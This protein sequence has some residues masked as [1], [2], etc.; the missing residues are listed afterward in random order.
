MTGP[1]RAWRRLAHGARPRTVRTRVT[2]IAGLAL[3]AAVIIGLLV[4]YLLQV[5][6][7]KRT[8]AGQL[9]TYAVQI[10]QSATGGA[11][12]QPLPPS[13]L[14]AQAQSQVLAPD[15]T[16]IASTRNL[17]GRPAVFTLAADATT[18]VRQKAADGVLPGELTVL[19]E[20][21]KVGGRPVTVI[22]LTAT[23]Q[24]D[25]VDETFARLLVIGVPGT[26]LV[27]CGT[28]WWVVGRAL[29][30][31]EQIRRTAT[32]IT[33]AELS[34]RVPEPG[35]DDEIGH[36]ARTMNDM[37]ARLDDSAARQR[38]FVADASHEL[39]SPL[40]AIR[41]A[42]E[43]GLAHPDRAPWP[44]IASRAA[45]QTERLE[46]LISQLLALA[47]ADAGKLAARRQTADLST[48]LAEIRATTTAPH[49]EIELA[50]PAHTTVTGNPEDLSR[51]FRNLIDNAARYAR[52]RVSVTAGV[53]PDGIRVEIGD[54]GPGIPVE[55]R[56]RVFDRFVR[57]D[58][59]RGHGTRSAGLGLP[60]AREIATA[61]GGTLT[62]T[63]TEGGGTRAVV[64]LP[65]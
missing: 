8:I 65:R 46:A 6:Q 58:A 33:A 60:I 53:E 32:A 28:V 63:E 47:R 22:T 9:R 41:T 64:T 7:A 44:D 62:L 26:L 42:L 27:A 51:L 34:Q 37:L 24:R 29:R 1:A 25:Q 43:V 50:V 23:N 61:H 49:L 10:E 59:D 3:T 14:D 30:P 2:V 11:F 39:R 15:G 4:M 56:E 21:T 36:L 5:G 12:P 13:V 38:R 54:D 35:T 17:A 55:E 40:T 19:G 16:V 31:V 52:T 18:P 45:R 57:L 48:L 20:H